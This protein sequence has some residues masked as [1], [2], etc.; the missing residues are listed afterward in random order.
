MITKIFCKRNESKDGRMITK[1]VRKINEP[2]NGR[3]IVFIKET[4]LKRQQNDNED[5]SYKK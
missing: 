1:V 4:S 3:K 2:K 5:C